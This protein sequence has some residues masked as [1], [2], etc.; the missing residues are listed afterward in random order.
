[1]DTCPVDVN[2]CDSK[3]VTAVHEAALDGHWD[4]LILLLQ[5]EAEVNKKDNQGL[6][7]LDYAVFGGHFECAQYFID[8]GAT[9]AGVRDGMPTY[10]TCNDWLE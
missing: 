3:G 1:M 9:T 8:N 10:F 7:C 5:H 2:G 4:V 6:T